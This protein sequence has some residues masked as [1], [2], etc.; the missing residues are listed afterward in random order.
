MVGSPHSS[1][2][3]LFWAYLYFSRYTTGPNIRTPELTIRTWAKIWFLF[4]A[5]SFLPVLSKGLKQSLKLAP[6]SLIKSLGHWAAET[7]L[8]LS[9]EL[10]YAVW[11]A[12][13]RWIK[14]TCCTP[15]SSTKQTLVWWSGQLLGRWVRVLERH[16]SSWEEPSVQQFVTGVL[17]PGFCWKEMFF[18]WLLKEMAPVLTFKCCKARQPRLGPQDG[19]KFKLFFSVANWLP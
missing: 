10:I 8:W 11:P 3:L 17:S 7:Q 4:P 13:A 15:P 5:A 16:L 6:L 9:G 12:P 19:V 18:A 1:S 14:S 2:C